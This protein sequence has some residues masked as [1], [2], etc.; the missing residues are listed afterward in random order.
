MLT[1]LQALHRHYTYVRLGNVY[2]II[3]L[4]INNYKLIFILEIL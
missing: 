4:I 3:N 1:K 2:I